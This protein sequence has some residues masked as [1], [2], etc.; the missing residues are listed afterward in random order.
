MVRISVKKITVTAVIA[1]LYA[2]MTLVGFSAAFGPI[3]LRFSEVL[4][5]LPFFIPCSVPGLFLGCLIANLV[6][7]YG[8]IDIVAG[9]MATLIAALMTMYIGRGKKDSTIVK[10][11]ACFPPVLVN[12]IVIGGVI[13]W[14]STSGGEAFWHSFAVFGLQVGIG[15]FVVMYFIGLPMMLYLPKSQLFSLLSVNS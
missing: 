12:A 9:S 1:A 10:A 7:P 3:Q 14:A 11:L 2:S 5:I 13:A 4:C 8:I 15:Q 6:S